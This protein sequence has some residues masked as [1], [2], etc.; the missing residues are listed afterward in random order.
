MLLICIMYENVYYP[1]IIL[2]YVQYIYIF[3][4]FFNIFFIFIFLM[5]FLYEWAM[6]SLEK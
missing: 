2:L 3:C 6:C 5:D 1:Y 4:I